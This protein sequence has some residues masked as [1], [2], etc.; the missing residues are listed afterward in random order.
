MKCRYV[1][2]KDIRRGR[3]WG[4]YS[5][6]AVIS[7]CETELINEVVAVLNTSIFDSLYYQSQYLLPQSKWILILKLF[8][9]SWNFK[10]YTP[11][12]TYIDKFL[13]WA[14]HDQCK[15]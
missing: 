8:L 15:I 9:F 2:K 4:E 6:N 11:L 5:E 10:K 12:Q 3:A 1:R 7:S 13:S 14:S